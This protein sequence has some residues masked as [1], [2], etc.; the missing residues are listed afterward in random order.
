MAPTGPSDKPENIMCRFGRFG[1]TPG[2][3]INSTMIQCITPATSMDVCHKYKYIYIYIYS[4]ILS[5][6]RKYT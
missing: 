2:A 6:V 4:Q 3:F 5:T 1:E